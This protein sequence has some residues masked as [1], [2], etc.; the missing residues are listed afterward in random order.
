M[1]FR[2][3]YG[4]RGPKRGNGRERIRKREGERIVTHERII[5]RPVFSRI[6]YPYTNPNIILQYDYILFPF[7]FRWQKYIN[8]IIDIESLRKIRDL[9]IIE[10]SRTNDPFL[11]EELNRKNNYINRII[12]RFII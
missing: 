7:D 1:S 6:N 10:K 2:K 12:E 11:M 3:G 8:N 9:I 5:E 4:N